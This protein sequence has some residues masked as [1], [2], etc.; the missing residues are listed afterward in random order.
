[1]NAHETFSLSITTVEH[2]AI[3]NYRNHLLRNQKDYLPSS[4]RYPNKGSADFICI[5]LNYFEQYK[6]K[7]SADIKQHQH[8]QIISESFLVDLEGV[9][10]FCINQLFEE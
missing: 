5:F 7:K 10:F 2:S 3:R 9:L 8:F 4:T 6:D 1:M